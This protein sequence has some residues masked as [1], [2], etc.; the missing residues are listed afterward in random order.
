MSDENHI[1]A[2]HIRYCDTKGKEANSYL[3]K[4]VTR[5][6]LGTSE[7]FVERDDSTG[8]S[9][10]NFLVD[11]V[12]ANP[13]PIPIIEAVMIDAT[14]KRSILFRTKR[15]SHSLGRAQT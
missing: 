9:G 4:P 8:G 1:V 3:K 7:V 12:S 2:R 14:G 15:P 11:W 13:V 6:P 5:G 10:S